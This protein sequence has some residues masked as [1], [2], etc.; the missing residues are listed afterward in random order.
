MD[1]DFTTLKRDFKVDIKK[2]HMHTE[3]KPR[4]FYWAISVLLK[5]NNL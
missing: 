1:P 4:S 3:V 2:V 5:G